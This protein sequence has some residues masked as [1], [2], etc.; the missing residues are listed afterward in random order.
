MSMPRPIVAAIDPRRSDLAPAALAAQLARVTAAPLVLA[1]AYPV[2]PRADATYPEYAETR[3]IETERAL[4]AAVTDRLLHGAP[5]PVAVAPAG[6]MPR[7]AARGPRLLGV[8]FVDSPDGLVALHAA[9]RLARRARALIRVLTVQ[10]PAWQSP[11]TT[12]ERVLAAGVA[13]VPAR[14]SGGGEILLGRPAD[15]LAAAS[16]DLDL[17]VCGCRGHGPVRTV[18]LGGTSHALVRSAACPVLVVPM[19]AARPAAHDP[20]SMLVLRHQGEA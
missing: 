15:A 7:S 17:L 12:A 19:S 11:E 13:R 10:E 3:R 20:G 5:C 1:A 6:F 8:A 2:D 18:V 14:Q 9:R 4:D 16:A